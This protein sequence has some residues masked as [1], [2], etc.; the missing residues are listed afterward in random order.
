MFAFNIPSILALGFIL[1]VVLMVLGYRESQ[2]PSRANLLFRAGLTFLGVMIALTPMVWYVYLELY[3]TGFVMSLSDMAIF[4]LG[5]FSGG[6]VTGV[7]A[8]FRLR[9]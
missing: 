3:L 7:G 6:T 1:A 9:K 5:M 8:T 2:T 4:G